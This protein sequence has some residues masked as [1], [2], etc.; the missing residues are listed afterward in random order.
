MIDLSQARWRKAAKSTGAN[1]GCVEIATNLP[2]MVVI[3]DSKHPE[4]GA[5]VLEPGRFGAFLAN[6]REGRYDL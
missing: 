5:H 6:V 1:T 2:G 4:V 3:R